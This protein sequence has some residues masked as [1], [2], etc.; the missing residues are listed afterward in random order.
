MKNDKELYSEF[1]EGSARAFEELVL[2]YKDNLIYFISRYTGG[3]LYTAEDIAQDVFAHLYVEKNSYDFKFEFKTYIFTIGRNKAVDHQRRLSR[4]TFESF[5]G[6]MELQQDLMTVEDSIVNSEDG[7]MIIK[8]I[9]SLKAD[10]ERALYLF[11]FEEL[12]YKEVARVMGKS[13]PQ[14]RI[15]IYRAREALK[16]K[17]KE[18]WDEN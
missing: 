8:G 14:V 5:Q 18:E 15:L 2:R 6:V 9:R 3:D 13:L 7:K 1:I 4:E 11:A 12:S 16:R 10:Q 17:L